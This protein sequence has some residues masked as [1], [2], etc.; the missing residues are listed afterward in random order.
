MFQRELSLCV[1]CTCQFSAHTEG[2][3]L[4]LNHPFSSPCRSDSEDEMGPEIEE[5]FE[6]FYLESER[7]RKQ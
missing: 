5:A 6:S 7:K 1:S 2:L 3:A 4:N